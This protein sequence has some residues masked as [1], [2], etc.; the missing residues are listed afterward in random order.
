MGLLGMPSP[1][2]AVRPLRLLISE[3][4]DT[5]FRIP[6]QVLNLDIGLIGL[7]GPIGMV[8]PTNRPHAAQCLILGALHLKLR[9][10]LKGTDPRLADWG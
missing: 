3:L 8:C 4:S 9:I 1:S 7:S 2:T 5:I 10:A 6:S